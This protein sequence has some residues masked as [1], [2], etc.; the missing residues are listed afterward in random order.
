MELRA[1]PRIQVGYPASI[2][3]DGSTGEGILLDL[4][5]AGCMMQSDVPLNPGSYVSLHITLA[6]EP[7]PLAVEVSVVRWT[8]GGHC[9]VEFLRFNQGDRERVINLL[10]YRP[11]R[12][13]SAPTSQTAESFN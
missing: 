1:R 12:D 11:Q 8:K 2:I 6:H 5:P 3:C 10:D 4:S 9:G 7:T 13:P